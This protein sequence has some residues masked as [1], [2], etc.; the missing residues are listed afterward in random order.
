MNYAAAPV[1]ALFREMTHLT[2]APIGPA[3]I[4][5]P[6]GNRSFQ[7]IDPNSPVPGANLVSPTHPAPAGWPQEGSM[8]DTTRIDAAD[9]IAAAVP[10]RSI[11]GDRR[12]S[13]QHA[14][15]HAA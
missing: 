3:H 13:R 12:I 8:T 1:L 2:V 15:G 5:G 9:P 11:S 14:L 4:D 6:A 10:V 7:A